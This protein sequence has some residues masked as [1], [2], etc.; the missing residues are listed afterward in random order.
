MNRK[1][2][3]IKA[4]YLLEMLSVA[5]LKNLT[6]DNREE[7]KKRLNDIEMSNINWNTDVVNSVKIRYN[8]LTNNKTII[9]HLQKWEDKD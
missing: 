3:R 8:A 4:D 7:I 5:Y 2:I 9:T 1:N 6:E